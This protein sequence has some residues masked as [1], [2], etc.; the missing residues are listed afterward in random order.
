[1]NIDI[2]RAVARL[3][4]R[5]PGIPLDGGGYSGC[6][7]GADCP[8]CLGKPINGIEAREV[9]DLHRTVT[10]IVDAV[11]AEANRL[12]EQLA[13]ARVA[14]AQQVAALAGRQAEA[15][16]AECDKLRAESGRLR[17]VLIASE[18]LTCDGSGQ[19]A[20]RGHERCTR[21]DGSGRVVQTDV[22][23]LVG[24]VNTLTLSRDELRAE[25]EQLQGVGNAIRLAK[26]RAAA[27][28]FIAAIEDPEGASPRFCSYCGKL[29]LTSTPD[30]KDRCGDHPN[31]G[32]DLSYAP[33]WRRLVALAQEG[34]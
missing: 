3:Q 4:F 24:Q 9:D 27:R 10:R 17:A 11:Y 34:T 8:V 30:G 15:A 6:E 7:G 26:L 23:R 5:C 33:A 2:A 12:A 19:I 31:G 14:E 16:R 29:A 20:T 18:C 13:A 1:M 21:C 22:E 25:L 32:T 28:E